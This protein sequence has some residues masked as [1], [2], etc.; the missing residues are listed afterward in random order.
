MARPQPVADQAERRQ[1]RGGQRERSP[2]RLLF[3]SDPV[4]AAA[5]LAGWP[6]A[7]RLMLRDA[8]RGTGAP[9]LVLPGLLAS[10]VST[11]PVR[12][13]LRRLGHHVHGWRLGRN[14]GPTPAVERGLRELAERLLERH[15]QP[16]SVI[17][18]SL[19]GIY[20]RAMASER[21]DAVRMVITLGTP[22]AMTDRTQTRATGQYERYAHLHV[23][24]YALPIPDRV[25][26]PLPVPSTSIWSRGDGIVSWRASLET[27]GPRA[28]NI[29]VRASHLGLGHSPGVLWAVADR[30]AQ[31]P[32]TWQPFRPPERLRR[33][34]PRVPDLRLVAGERQG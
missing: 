22:F 27:P 7:T 18:W 4:R 16:F 31:P 19:G 9:V 25:R 12:A 15:G 20:A 1:D 32:G 33:L 17:G 10:D 8:P 2:G 30:L 3:A 6:V 24:G 11:R 28:E 26:G 5:G 13:V 21:P 29:A 34:Y 23:P 14:L